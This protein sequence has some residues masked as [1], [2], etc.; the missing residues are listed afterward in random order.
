VNRRRACAIV[1]VLAVLF[2]ANYGCAPRAA[3]SAAM[4]RAGVS[5]LAGKS[6]G[7]DIPWTEVS[8]DDLAPAGLV[9]RQCWNGMGMDDRG[10]VYIGF[11]STRADGREDV[12]V[13]RYDPKT[14]ERSFLGTL[15]DVVAAAGNSREGESIP[16]GHTRLI[17]ADGR[18]YLGSQSFHDLK[19]PIDSLPSYRGS[20]LFAFDTEAGTWQDLSAPLASGVVTEHEGI[21]SLNILRGEHLLV[22]LAHPSSDIVLYDYRASRLVEVVPGIPWRQGN[23]LS[24]EIVAAPSGRIFTYRGTEDPA[25]RNVKHDVWVYDVRT[26]RMRD[27]GIAMANGF[28]IGQTEKRDGSMVYVST[29]TGGLYGFDTAAETFRDLGVMLPAEQRDAGRQILFAYAITLSPDERRIF[30]VLS[31]LDQPRGSGELYAYDLASGT[32]SFVQQLPAGI[33]TSADLRDGENIYF[34]HF[35]SADEL[36]SG[37]PRLF[38][39]HVPPEL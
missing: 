17:F 32:I 27:T 26:G 18:M 14:R 36:W 8:F 9:L 33:Y 1:L 11:T 5:F 30:I 29:T 37:R 34:S 24:R 31:I 38:M 25:Q 28:W 22:G 35:G 39:L 4:V 20:H 23:P 2:L 13:F 16:K 3:T 21:V 7:T 15:L 12:S 19:G 6:R 10:R